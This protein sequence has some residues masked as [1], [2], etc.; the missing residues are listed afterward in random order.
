MK[1]QDG[2]VFMLVL[3]MSSACAPAPTRA[4]VPTPF[5]APPTP[6]AKTE[7][8]PTP[9]PPVSSAPEIA[10]LF[11]C[12]DVNAAGDVPVAHYRNAAGIEV[13]TFDPADKW[14]NQQIVW[15]WARMTAFEKDMALRWLFNPKHLRHDHFE[16]HEAWLTQVLA[17]WIPKLDQITLPTEPEL[18]VHWQSDGPPMQLDTVYEALSRIKAVALIRERRSCNYAHSHLGLIEYGGETVLFSAAGWRTVSQDS[19]EIFTTVWTVKEAMVIYYAQFIGLPNACPSASEH[20]KVEYYSTL[21]LLQAERALSGF[22]PGDRAYWVAKEIPFQMRNI[23]TQTFPPCQATWTPAPVT[24][25]SPTPCS[26][27]P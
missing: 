22:V 27:E 10:G 14:H 3:S 16:N 17:R 24:M 26:S 25:P 21:W 18:A 13:A 12:A 11:A 9:C 1:L 8:A 19:R 15:H 23:K 5:F 6:A 20:L 7:S 2:I 4:P